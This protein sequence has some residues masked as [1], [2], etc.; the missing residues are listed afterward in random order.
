M[1]QTLRSEPLPSECNP[2]IRCSRSD[3]AV[4]YINKY[5]IP[6]K[7]SYEEGGYLL[8]HW[9]G[10]TDLL[11]D[12]DFGALKRYC[13]GHMCI[14]APLELRAKTRQEVIDKWN[15]WNPDKGKSYTKIKYLMGNKMDT[16][17]III[18][19]IVGIIVLLSLYLISFIK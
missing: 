13:H 7:D 5:Y 17:D 2:C 12:N 4:T 3:L 11:E 6:T 14:E 18:I 8:S 1:R 10:K 19:V 15:L 9:C 16:N